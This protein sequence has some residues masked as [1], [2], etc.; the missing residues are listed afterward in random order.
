MPGTR[1]QEKKYWYSISVDSLKALLVLVAVAVALVLAFLG[2]QV[3]EQDHEQ[4]GAARNLEEA[5]SLAARL[6][7]EGGL[8]S[9]RR[10]YS[11]ALETY[12]SARE[13]YQA[14]QYRDA[15]AAAAG[16]RTMLQAIYDALHGNGSAGEARFITVDG[17]VSFR[18]GETGDWESAR[19]RVSLANGDFVRTEGNGSAAVMLADGTLY[20]IRPNTLV[21]IG[22]IRTNRG[23]A[24]AQSME[25]EYGWVNL[26]TRSQESN[27]STPEAEA[28]VERQS[29][30]SVSYDRGSRTGRFASYR[31]GLRVAT[32]DGEE[33]RIAGL[34]QVVQRRERLSQPE[35]LP[36]SPEL[37]E[38]ANNYQASF[39][40]DETVVLAWKPLPGVREY[41]L[42]VS[43]SS[44]FV[45]NV[46]DRQDRSRPG[47][48]LGIRGE[49]TF[50]WR[51]AAIDRN[52]V[53]GPWSEPR[54]FRVTSLVGASERDTTPPTI[55]LS[56]V[57]AY[58]NIFIVSGRTE[59][60]AAVV[61]NDEPV[62]V[63][64]DGSFTKSVQF[65]DPDKDKYELIVVARDA[66]GN[67]AEKR[68][69]VRI[70]AF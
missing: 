47:A 54:K 56:E 30:A 70:E 57:K 51:V 61:I 20:T 27:V 38:P 68:R 2:Y 50:L 13:S 5:R 12:Q 23:G 40:V 59:P 66:W 28:R 45:D 41:A 29:Q 64:S 65:N 8:S 9:F 19:G 24:T 14:E 16:S 11:K 7:S 6:E 46:I 58:G 31:G 1:S 26:S 22:G 18:R 55:E 4:R 33:Q 60:G 35:S 21:K 62:A 53:Q 36:R 37:S 25:M 63:A 42:Q 3:W 43:Q 69:E 17:G 10:E 44:L 34:R 67:E 32:N 48:T 39:G 15:L 49:G 52:G